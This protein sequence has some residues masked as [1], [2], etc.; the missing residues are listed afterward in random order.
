M[1]KSKWALVVLLI[2]PCIA[3]AA[4][5]T[6]HMGMS[7]KAKMLKYRAYFPGKK[8]VETVGFVMKF[9]ASKIQK[10]CK[11]EHVFDTPI[12]ASHMFITYSGKR[13]HCRLATYTK[14]TQIFSLWG[15]KKVS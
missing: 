3:L 8:P 15:C 2:S 6:L 10:A 9:S 13:Y 5:S 11:V 4:S 14:A 12:P 7:T 1:F